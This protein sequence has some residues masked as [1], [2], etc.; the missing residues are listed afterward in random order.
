M[1][2][3]RLLPAAAGR[4]HATHGTPYIAVVVSALL[5]LGMPLALFFFGSTLLDIY[6]YFGTLATFGF[7]MAYILISIAGPLELRREKALS[8]GALGL[9]LITIVLLMIP[10]VG[11]VYPLP[12]APMSYLPVIFVG[13]LGIGTVWFLYLRAFQPDRF[14]AVEQDSMQS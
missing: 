12:P 2:R 8:A 6:G 11:S 13:L 9:A 5:V 1:A 4:A 10:A 3:H 7:L 14:R